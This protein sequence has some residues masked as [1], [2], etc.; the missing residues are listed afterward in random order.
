[1]ATIQQKA[2]AIIDHFTSDP[3]LKSMIQTELG[4]KQ[5]T[6]A[7]VKAIVGLFGLDQAT[8]DKY[9]ESILKA[10]GGLDTFHVANY[11]IGD[12][13]VA[14]RASDSMSYHVKT[15]KAILAA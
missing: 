11:H 9:V 5:G 6:E 14:S 3:A 1:M 7:T 13:A 15:V 4:R 2:S 10:I 8:H 12:P